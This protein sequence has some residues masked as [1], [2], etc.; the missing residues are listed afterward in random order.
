MRN[1]KQTVCVILFAVIPTFTNCQ[2]RNIIDVYKE[3]LLA[4][5][6]GET[7]FILYDPNPNPF[8]HSTT[9]SLDLLE[10]MPVKLWVTNNLGQTIRIL[11]NSELVAGYHQI[12]FNGQGLASGVYTFH[13]QAEDRVQIRIATKIN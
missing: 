2:H 13:L 4:F 11:I 6:R 9:L 7:H 5:I 3:D 8:S 10:T 12:V 1:I